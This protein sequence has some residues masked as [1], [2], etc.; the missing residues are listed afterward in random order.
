MYSCIEHNSLLHALHFDGYDRPRYAS[1]DSES[2][3]KE[4]YHAA[5]ASGR[6]RL[7]QVTETSW[8]SCSGARTTPSVIG[9]AR[10]RDSTESRANS[11]LPTT[12]T[13]FTPR[14]TEAGASIPLTSNWENIFETALGFEGSNDSQYYINDADDFS[15]SLAISPAIAPTIKERAHG[16]FSSNSSTW[17]RNHD[18]VDELCRGGSDSEPLLASV[19]AVGMASFANT[20]QGPKLLNRARKDYVKA[21]RLTNAALR[22]PTEVKKDSTLFSVVILSLFEMVAGWNEHSLEAWNEHINGASALITL[23]GVEQFNTRAG[24]PLFMQVT[25]N[26]MVSCTQRTLPIPE[27][28]VELRQVVEKL[29]APSTWPGGGYQPWS[30]I[31]RS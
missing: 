26:I 22:S 6:I 9:N 15:S 29:M 14:T 12:G 13:S 31:S 11:P 20:I 21:L 19:S 18:L 3:T 5:N 7:A 17:L 16:Y 1:A 2:V 28:I 24:Q 4:S 27:H 10:V 23:R 25:S 8:I 30:S